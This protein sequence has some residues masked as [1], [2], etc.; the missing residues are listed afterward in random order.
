MNKW[1]DKYKN[2]PKEYRAIPFWS[3]NYKLDPEFL[4]WQIQEMDKAGLGGYFMHARGGLKT[5]YMS[6][7]WMECIRACIDE[8]NKTGLKSWSYDEEGW[9]SGFAGGIVTGMGDKYHVRWLEIEKYNGQET[10]DGDQV[11][12]K[13][14]LDEE[15]ILGTYTFDPETDGIHYISYKDKTVL[16]KGK[17]TEKSKDTFI[18]KHKSNPY[19]IDILNPEVIRAFI[20]STYEKYYNIFKDDFGKGMPGFFTD[21]PQFS[22]GKIPWSYIL[23]ERFKERFGYDLI[24]VLPSLFIECKG[25]EEVRYD[26]WSLVNDLY[27]N[28]FGK[29]IYDWC[30]EHNCQFT[31]HVMM[32]DSM[33]TQMGA[34]AGGMPFYKYMHIPGMDWLGRAIQ[35]PVI[36]KQVSSVA[37]QLGKEFVLS[38]TFALCGW[39]VSFEEL[40][41]IAEWQ[42]VNGVNL[43]CQHLEGYTLRGLRK[44]DYPASLFYQQ[45]WW[46][47]YRLFNDYFARL[48]VLLTSGKEGSNVLLLHPMKSAWIA[49]N[50]GNSDSLQKLDK[51]FVEATSALSGLHIGHHYGDETIIGQ[52]GKVVGNEFILGLC[53]Y[54]VVIMPSMI[55]IDEVTVDLLNE[56]TNNGGK[57]I[58]IGDFPNLCSDKKKL[59][60]L[61]DSIT[62]IKGHEE[63]GHKEK[64]LEKLY[65]FLKDAQVSTISI[66]GD[67]GDISSI[68]YM[69]RDI[70]DE[71]IFFLVNHDQNETFNAI[72]SIPGKGRLRKITVEDGEIIDLEFDEEDGQIKTKLQFLPMQSHVLI[73]DKKIYLNEEQSEHTRKS[74]LAQ[75]SE[76]EQKYIKIATDWDIEK[77]GLNS[78]TLD[79]C[80]YRIN[81]GEWERSL[82][83]IKLMDILL[84]LK[85]SC[86]IELKFNF[87]VNMNL[88][89]NKELFLAL[90]K[91]E[92]FEISINGEQ[93]KYH[94]Q[95]WWKDSSFKKVDIKN[96]VQLGG[97]EIL[98][99]RTFY[100]AQK[101]YDVL[102][103]EDVL[104]TEKNKLTF[105]VEFESIYVVGDFG[106][107]S[108][109]TYSE[110][111]RKA[112]FTDGP[113]VILDM[114]Q[115]VKT[116][117]L[118]QQ[119]FCFFADTIKLGQNFDLIIA[120]NQ[121]IILDLGK[122]DAVLSKVFIN[123]QLVK[124]LL[125]APYCIDITDFIKPG[126]NRLSVELFPG[127]RN[128]LGPHHHIEGELYSV[129]P[130]SFTDKPGWS[131]G[132]GTKT[133][134][135]DGYCFVRFG[136]R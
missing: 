85:S 54:K 26:F 86:E 52:H 102:F 111:K 100:Q 1:M 4:R 82:P 129:G 28:S 13:Y 24:S 21:E 83:I 75:E 128:L 18:I 125:W 93:L 99:K 48:G 66:F 120:E 57:V 123:D 62:H 131:D 84:N 49:Y 71:Q 94:D 44:R 122:P 95:G 89:K 127:N 135:R 118:T 79:Y 31:G 43:M 117:D 47:E 73:F 74:K 39:D 34:T 119:G 36:P 65:S 114:P 5:E 27:V 90:E 19:Y 132:P 130:S 113:F 10:L 41:W 67:E 9:P 42:Y 68:H 22:R 80:S 40:K 35:S 64:S 88:G 105:D 115:N 2:P 124:T 25:Y 107:K 20:E 8:G 136:L 104:E 112:L 11:L 91:A 15:Q 29:Q 69:R 51:E 17:E 45:S 59:K 108:K 101:V 7:D 110:G 6:E 70:G 97:N 121:R 133:I 46:S 37:N 87:E 116:G 126:I 14:K 63:K 109:S 98:L 55:H 77:V 30:E 60:Q 103:G 58:S 23:P 50:S 81:G 33:F 134:W 16:E 56:F 92:E 96:C 3:W 53:N 72:I 78:I 38:E 106:V 12:G 32:E 76:H 61:K